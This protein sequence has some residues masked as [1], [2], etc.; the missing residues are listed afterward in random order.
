MRTDAIEGARRSRGDEAEDRAERGRTSSEDRY[1]IELK[2]ISS[3]SRSRDKMASWAG[4]PSIKGSTEGV[5][6]GLLTLTAMGLQYVRS[7]IDLAEAN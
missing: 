3:R 4:Q 7:P 1:A 5:R 6:M 2:S